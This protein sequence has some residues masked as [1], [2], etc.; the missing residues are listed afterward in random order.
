MLDGSVL[1]GS[2]LDAVAPALDRASALAD[3]LAELL[4]QARLFS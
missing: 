2:V 4:V 3:Q 1:D